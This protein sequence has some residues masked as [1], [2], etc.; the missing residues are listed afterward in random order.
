[1][2]VGWDLEVAEAREVY[3]NESD[4]WRY[5]QQFLLNSTHTTTYK[6]ILMK[7]LLECVSEMSDSGRL[8]FIQISKHVTKMYWNLIVTHDLHHINTKKTKSG[9]EKIMLTFQEKHSIPKFWTFD[10]LPSD[11]KESL[12][13]S[14]NQIYKKYVY[15]SFYSSFDGTIYSFH[16]KEE[17]LQL[18]PPY[19]VFFEKYKR[20]LMNVTNYQLALF[21]EKYNTREAMEQILSK[22]EFISARQSLEEF[23]NLLLSYGVH[24]CFYCSKPLRKIHVDHFIP[25]SYVQ[26][27]LLWN[28]VLACPSCNTSKNNRIAHKD[29]LHALVDRNN[30]W[31]SNEWMKTYEEK[32]LVNMYGYAIQN[33]CKGD[34]KPV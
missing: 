3:L 17:W 13:K 16:K 2:R 4:L 30:H 32:K 19:I 11:Q 24:D 26:N 31:E 10:K 6:H 27:D 8:T 21:L 20:I 33:G 1:M 14:V 9:V 22:V 28:F 23:K 34:W 25:W 29:F 12:I 7:A 18:V 15:G 5:T